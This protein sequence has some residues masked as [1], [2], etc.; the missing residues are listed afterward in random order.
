MTALIER[1]PSARG[2]LAPMEAM[3]RHTWFGV[4]GAAE[5]MF[6]PADR[7]DLAE[8]LAATPDDIPVFAFGAGSNLLVREGGIKGVVVHTGGL[9]GAD[10]EDGMLRVGAGLHDAEVARTAAR[11]GIAGLEFLV[12]IPGTIGG[13]LRMNAGAY[14]AEFK[15]IVQR[16]EAVDRSGRLH[17]ATPAEMGMAYR[18]SD[19]PDDW[20]FTRAWLRIERGE[21][22]SI[23][24]R[25]KEIIASR[26][27]AQPSGVRTGGSTFANPDGGKAWRLI[28]EAGCRG[29]TRGKAM[30]SEKHCNFLINKGGASAEAIEELG[31]TVRRR[32]SE[33]SGVELRWEIRRIGEHAGEGVGG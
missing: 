20:I 27:D 15:D 32:V 31:E 5:V 18:H 22:D 26:A 8:F 19:A 14:G 24:A 1:L 33:T 3:S 23:R 28:E 16:A 10:E 29:L 7:S 4:G 9:V 21:T 12:G 2:A 13:G 25:M 30:V 11:M 6:T 17:V